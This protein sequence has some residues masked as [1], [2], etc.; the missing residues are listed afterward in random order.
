VQRRKHEKG[1]QIETT[2]TTWIGKIIKT[3]GIKTESVDL[4]TP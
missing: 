3:M 2:E 4:T 1:S